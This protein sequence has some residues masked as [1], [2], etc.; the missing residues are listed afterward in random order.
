MAHVFVNTKP[1]APWAGSTL[2]YLSTTMRRRWWNITAHFS[3]AASCRRWN[4]T[5]H[6]STA[7]RCRRWNIT[8]HLSTAARCR[9][10]NITAH[11][12]I[13]SRCLPSSYAYSSLKSQ[14]ECGL[15]YELDFMC[16]EYTFEIWGG[17]LPFCPL[18]FTVVWALRALHPCSGADN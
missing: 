14:S 2:Q 12:S 1:N 5:A 11:L 17:I 9:W 10:W 8:A 7:A 6:L 3:T 15:E 4:I 18:L 16:L 13:T